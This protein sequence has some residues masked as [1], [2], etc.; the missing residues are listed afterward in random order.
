MDTKEEHAGVSRRPAKGRALPATHC[1]VV[2]LERLE[3]VW[4]CEV[5]HWMGSS[6]KAF[7]AAL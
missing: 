4:A 1:S 5:A 7:E 6:L 2:D 3:V